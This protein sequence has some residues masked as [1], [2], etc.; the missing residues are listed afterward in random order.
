[1]VRLGW[2]LLALVGCSEPVVE[3]DPVQDLSDRIAYAPAEPAERVPV[4]TL[5]AE[6]LPAPMTPRPG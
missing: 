2:G 3:A 4:T 1:M 5:P 6:V